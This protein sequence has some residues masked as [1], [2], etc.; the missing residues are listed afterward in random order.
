MCNAGDR[1]VVNFVLNDEQRMMQS[2]AADFARGEIAPGAAAIRAAGPATLPW[3]IVAPLYRKGAALGFH[4]LLIPE[5]YGGLGGSCFDNVLVMEEFG[6]ADHGIAASYFN[7]SMTAPVAL[8]FGATE[9]QKQVWLTAIAGADDCVLASASSEPSVAGADSFYPGDDPRIGLRSTAVRD[10]ECYVLNGQ[11]SGFSTNAGAAKILFVMA[12]TATDRPARDS[13]S[14]FVVPADLPGVHVG[15]RTDLIGWKT[16][17]HA[18][19]TFDGVRVPLANRI[20]AEGGNTGLFFI[21]TLPFL[22]AGLAATY[23]GLA[24]AAFELA[25]DYA[26]Q[27]YSWGKPIVEHQMVAIKL[28]DMAAEIEAARLMV[29]RLAAAADSGD[30]MAAGLYAPA[31]KTFAVQTAIRCAER[32]IKILGGYGAATDFGAGR[33]LNDAWIGDSCDGTHDLL[34]LNIV[35][36]LRVMRGKLAPPGAPPPAMADA[37]GTGKAQ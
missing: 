31:A 11:K 29:W 17:M 18:E 35:H 6:A 32:A 28:A 37:A 10:G 30:P 19:V 9:E 2:M 26:H 33:L 3:E 1:T 15:A 27:R 25:F 21:K 7:V 22:A 23:V 8:V 16:A 24:R 4:R 20:G 5:A 36:F 12:R 34:R 14:M 13:T